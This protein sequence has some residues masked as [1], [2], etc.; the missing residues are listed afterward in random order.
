MGLAA[1]IM[2]VSIQ[3]TAGKLPWAVK[4]TSENLVQSSPLTAG[5]ARDRV[6]MRYCPFDCLSHVSHVLQKDQGPRG[7]VRSD[8]LL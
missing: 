5:A 8:S 6:F 1:P 4:L 2:I 3:Q 7:L